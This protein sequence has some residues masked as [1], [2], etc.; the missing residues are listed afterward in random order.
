MKAVLV[1]PGMLKKLMCNKSP[2][3][4]RSACCAL[5]ALLCK[6]WAL[7]FWPLLLRTPHP[8]QTTLYR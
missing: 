2:I 6:R 3:P 7:L 5:I 4:V 8:G 1:A